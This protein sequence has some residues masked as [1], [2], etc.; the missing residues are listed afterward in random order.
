METAA[1][2]QRSPLLHR[3]INKVMREGR[4]D[5]T[6]GEEIPFFCECQRTDCHEPIWLTAAAYDERR[7]EAH[8]PAHIAGSRRSTPGEEMA[9][10][11]SLNELGSTAG[12]NGAAG[13]AAKTRAEIRCESCGYGAVVDR[14]PPHCPMC[15]DESWIVVGP[16]AA[17]QSTQS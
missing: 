2:F 5:R 13:K 11:A 3:R 9:A 12:R 4:R 1:A 16:D 17:Q 7:T 8:R 6:D 14:R 15:G 10:S